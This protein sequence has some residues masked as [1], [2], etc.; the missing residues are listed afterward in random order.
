MNIQET[1]EKKERVILAGVHTG[2]VD[3]LK[4]TDEISLK[5][6]EEL[7]KTAG[8][9]VIAV[10]LQNRPDIENATYFGEGKLEEL[11]EAV[12]AMEADTVIFDDELSPIQLRNITD[13]LKVKVL[14]RA[15]L[16][17]D[18]FS[19]HARS[20]EGKLQVELAQL[21]YRLPR[22]RGMGD[23]MSRTGAGI[24]TRGP[25]ETRLETD[26][27]HIHKRISAL[28]TDIKEIKKHRDLIRTRRQKDG[29]ITAALVGYTNAG[30]S[31]LLNT[32]TD[33]DVYAKDKLFATLDPTSRGLTLED[34][35]TILLTDTVGFIRKLPH[36]LVE[37]F[38]STLEEAKYADVLIHVIDSSSDGA[39]DQIEIVEGVLRDIGATS[40]TIIGVYNKCDIKMPEVLKT[41]HYAEN[42]TISAKTGI[43]IDRL[44]D[45]IVKTAPG[46]KQ[47]MEIMLPYSEG[48]TLSDIHENQKVVTEDY[49]AEGVYVKLLADAETFDKLRKYQYSEE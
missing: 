15:M 18:I 28:E 13:R 24:G 22:L 27:R 14:D 2:R 16:I 25:G 45:K 7:T 29:F 43:N 40:A 3:R 26:R 4:D 23:S 33:A 48:S 17:L 10:M 11:A 49:R 34:N 47:E 8:G 37:A 5:E 41:V 1:M 20:G 9:E 46:Q 42:V 36:H 32:L 35:R 39:D 19:M 44:I 31:T 21:K 38:K 30:K 12:V 6:L